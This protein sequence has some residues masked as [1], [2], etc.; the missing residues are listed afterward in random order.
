V[1]TAER[2]AKETLSSLNII[3]QAGY[4][5]PRMLANLLKE[6]DEIV[7]ILTTIARKAKGKPKRQNIE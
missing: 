7:A 4:F 5:E 3:N 1:E 6:A 2:E